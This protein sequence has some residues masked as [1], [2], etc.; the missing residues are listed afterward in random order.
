MLSTTKG[1]H[2]HVH[3][4]IAVCMQRN[5][6]TLKFAHNNV[7][8]RISNFSNTAFKCLYCLQIPQ[9]TSPRKQL[10]HGQSTGPSGFEG[11]NIFRLSSWSLQNMHE[12]ITD[13]F[14]HFLNLPRCLWGF[15]ALH[16]ITFT[17]CFKVIS[18][19]TEL[20]NYLISIEAAK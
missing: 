4:Q 5:T 1:T 18:W 3:A 8:F 19:N 15:R 10:D 9:Q 2:L 20:Q 12:S 11:N 14:T 16:N 17:L 13:A 6:F 7:T